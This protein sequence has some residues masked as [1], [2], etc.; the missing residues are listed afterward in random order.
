[1]T[2]NSDTNKYHDKFKRALTLAIAPDKNVAAVV[3]DILSISKES[4]Y[5]RLR[6][7]SP[8][9]LTEVL[10]LRE[11][12][13]ISIDDLTSNTGRV[14]FNFKPIC[15]EPQ[16]FED[17]LKDIIH[18]FKKLAHVK[19]SNTTNV[20]E[21]LPFFRQFGYPAL[22]SFKIFYWGQSI[23]QDPYYRNKKYSPSSIPDHLLELTQ[24]IHE[25]YTSTNSTEIWTQKTIFN[26]L[27]Q[28][29]YYESCGLFKSK[30][31]LIQ[32]YEDIIMLINDLE[33]DATNKFKTNNLKQGGGKFS[34]YL[35]ELSLDNN[36]IFLETNEPK[37]I[38][39]GFNSFNS[40]QS[41]DPNILDEYKSWLDA[42]ISKSISISGQAQ[43]IR[44]DFF[45]KNQS[46]IHQSMKS[47]LPHPI[48]E[49]I[50]Q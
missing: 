26:T 32:L 22:A 44:R 29:E 8:F 36:S 20:C 38:A 46:L 50:L 37:Y 19:T 5:R 10:L 1:M 27:A 17:Y 23:T 34:L 49:K 43:K 16:L 2:L 25:L 28:I 39:L 41:I 4:A 18:R 9:S 6:G 48:F 7:A 40:I 30:K 45:E 31:D 47:K 42:M 33:H 14:N 3:A 15:K 11:R 13:N 35:S 12:L 24:Q 21:D